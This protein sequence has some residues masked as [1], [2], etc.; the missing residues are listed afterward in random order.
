MRLQR[1]NYRAAVSLNLP[2][3]NNLKTI[4][5]AALFTI[6]LTACK[7]KEP[8]LID[9]NYLPNNTYW[10]TA[11]AEINGQTYICKSAAS[12]FNKTGKIGIMIA[13]DIIPDYLRHRV[14]VN[15]LPPKTGIYHLPDR[16]FW[17]EQPENVSFGWFSQDALISSYHQLKDSTFL[18]VVDQLD[19]I[20]GDISGTYSGVFVTDFPEPENPA[21]DTVRIVGGVFNTKIG[22]Q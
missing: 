18:L 5:C 15:H 22:R 6:A 20:S 13:F 12:L 11:S 16:V 19:T 10:G 7:Q 17:D 2:P 9:E 4:L 14:S 3:M 21:P 1:L 8:E